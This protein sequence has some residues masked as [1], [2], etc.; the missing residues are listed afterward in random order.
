MGAVKF[1]IHLKFGY[2]R[3]F[4]ERDLAENLNYYIRQ[5]WRILDVERV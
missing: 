4:S 2:C 5:G 1:V 3:C